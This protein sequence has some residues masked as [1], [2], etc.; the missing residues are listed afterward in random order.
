MMNFCKLP[1]FYKIYFSLLLAFVILLIVFSTG[2]RSFVSSYNEGIPETVSKNFFENTFVSLDTDKIIEMS[3]IEKSEFETYGDVEAFISSHMKDLSYTG[4]SSDENSDVRKYIVKS[5]EYMIASFSLA[6]DDKGDYHPETLE[7]HLPKVFEKKIKLLDS[8]ALFVNG[9][10][11]PDT[12]VVSREEHKDKAYLP[13]NVKPPEWLIYSVSGLTKEPEIVITDRNGNNITPTEG[14][15]GVLCEEVIYDTP[16][17][18]IV[19]RLLSAAKQYAKCMQDDASKASVFEYYEKGTD[20]YESIRTVENMFVW[21]HSGYAFE[22]EKVSE[23]M[24]YD[25]NT[26]SVRISFTHIL[27]KYGKQ[28]YRDK[29]DITFYARNTDGKYLIFNQHNNT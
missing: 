18:D 14:D 7:L 2:L 19:N 24:R 13:S 1:L 11:V 26:V 8:S 25:E 15:D 4:I 12:Y 17:A 27:K 28:D 6:P 5:G 20:I 9:I 22:D 16:E 29:T 10:L 3:G 23:F 21:D